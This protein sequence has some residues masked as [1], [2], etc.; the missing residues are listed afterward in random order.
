VDAVLVD[1]SK[2]PHALWSAGYLDAEVTQGKLDEIGDWSG[3]TPERRQALQELLIEI[4]EHLN[5]VIDGDQTKE[6][7]NGISFLVREILHK[8][9]LMATKPGDEDPGIDEQA[10]S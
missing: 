8:L 2:H 7:R 3:A 9:P 4:T 10:A 6:M 5:Q 1:G